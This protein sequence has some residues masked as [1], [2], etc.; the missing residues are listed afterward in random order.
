MAGILKAVTNVFGRNKTDRTAPLAL[1]SAIWQTAQARLDAFDRA[2]AELAPEMPDFYP[3]TLALLRRHAVV[4]LTN[5]QRYFDDLGYAHRVVLFHVQPEHI[6][7]GLDMLEK[8][9][10]KHPPMTSDNDNSDDTAVRRSYDIEVLRTTL[11]TVTVSTV[12]PDTCTEELEDVLKGTENRWLKLEDVLNG[13]EGS[14][15]SLV[16]LSPDALSQTPVHQL[17]ETV[18]QFWERLPTGTRV[19]RILQ[20]ALAMQHSEH[21]TRLET[22]A[23]TDAQLQARAAHVKNVSAETLND[24]ARAAFAQTHALLFDRSTED[25]DRA[26]PLLDEVLADFLEA[27]V[28]N[29]TRERT[30]EAQLADYFAPGGA[31]PNRTDLY[32]RAEIR[33][34]ARKRARTTPD[35]GDELSIEGSLHRQKRARTTDNDSA[36]AASPPPMTL[37]PPPTTLPP[38]P[39]TLPPPPG[40]A[41]Q[42]QQPQMAAPLNV[43]T[44][45]DPWARSSW[46]PPAVMQPKR[47]QEEHMS[48]WTDASAGA[49]GVPVGAAATT[50]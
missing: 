23:L 50:R 38:P 4:P 31:I 48:V 35:S 22:T 36:P 1:P 13:T 16:I 10:G 47:T 39:T 7:H 8:A 5:P 27:A 42:P 17:S 2:I 19:A 26:G 12:A 11:D 32:S 37:P 30:G 9:C 15:L 25:F 40:F 14:W 20:R 6:A 3:A 33:L 24:I 29:S 49:L 44:Q 28:K 18:P 41:L 43:V 45:E 34:A 46:T 21:Y